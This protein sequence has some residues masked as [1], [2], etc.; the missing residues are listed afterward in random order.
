MIVAHLVGS[1]HRFG[2][3]KVRS[4]SIREVAERPQADIAPS[5]RSASGREFDASELPAKTFATK[6]CRFNHAQVVQI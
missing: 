4:G 2:H 3:R 5:H 6:F 1:G